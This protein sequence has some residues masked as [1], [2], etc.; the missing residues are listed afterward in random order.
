MIMNWRL[1][2]KIFQNQRYKE[3]SI[4][5]QVEGTYTKYNLGTHL[6][7]GNPQMGGKS[8]L[9]RFIPRNEVSEPQ[10]WLPSPGALYQEDNS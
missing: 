2:E 3:E 5:R 1:V 9:Q 6:G 7:V 10:I 4:I 8:Q